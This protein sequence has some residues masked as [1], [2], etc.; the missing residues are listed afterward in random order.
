MRCRSNAIPSVSEIL[1]LRKWGQRGKQCQ[2]VAN[3]PLRFVLV[4]RKMDFGAT[5]E[6][7]EQEAKPMSGY[8]ID[9]RSF[10]ERMAMSTILN[11]Y[12]VDATL[13]Y[14]TE[15]GHD[16]VASSD[17]LKFG[18]LGTLTSSFKSK[19][20][21]SCE[22]F[23]VQKHIEKIC[24]SAQSVEEAFY[25][26]QCDPRADRANVK[27]NPTPNPM[28]ELAQM[29]ATDFNQVFRSD[30]IYREVASYKMIQKDYKP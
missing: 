17:V 10:C 13:N 16:I 3:K 14:A 15:I 11:C 6:K 21:T 25:V 7:K 29:E 5:A 8:C 30:S 1:R 20:V 23:N 22:V 2:T 4:E 26:Y 28:K 12:G 24:S 19:I 27:I 18:D 9:F